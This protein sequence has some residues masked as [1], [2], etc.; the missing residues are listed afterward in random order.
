MEWEWLHTHHAALHH[1]DRAAEAHCKE[2]CSKARHQVAWDA[3]FKQ[4]RCQ[5]RLLNLRHIPVLSL[6]TKCHTSECRSI[7]AFF[8]VMFSEQLFAH[9]QTRR[10]CNVIA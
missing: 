7:P 5:Q 10:L 9:I 2:A 6:E 4:P 1:V 8:L 3:V